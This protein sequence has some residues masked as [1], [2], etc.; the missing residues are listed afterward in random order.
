MVCKAR[1][2][3]L[4]ALL[5]A[6]LVLQALAAEGDE[7]L[8]AFDIKAQPLSEAL[9]EFGARASVSVVASSELTRDKVAKPFKGRLTRWQALAHLLQGTGLGFVRSP[10]GAIVIVPLPPPLPRGKAT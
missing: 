2:S 1:R 10:D 9:M 8:F 3:V 6:G 4:S 5:A 7:G